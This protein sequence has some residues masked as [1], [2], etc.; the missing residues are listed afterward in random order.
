MCQRLY[1]FRRVRT[2]ERGVLAAL[3]C[4]LAFVSLNI[5]QLLKLSESLNVEIKLDR[6]VPSTNFK[7]QPGYLSGPLQHFQRQTPSAQF[8]KPVELPYGK[9]SHCRTSDFR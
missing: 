6:S 8:P 7:R 3:P 2:S 9:R 4:G 1:R 5:S